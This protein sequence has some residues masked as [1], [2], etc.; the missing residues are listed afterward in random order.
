MGNIARK[1]RPL[2]VDNRAATLVQVHKAAHEYLGT[3]VNA[4]AAKCSSAELQCNEQEPHL[5]L[6]MRHRGYLT[7]PLPK[8]HKRLARR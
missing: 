5:R 6:Y 4:I 2:E 1:W 8:I 7:Q 3:S